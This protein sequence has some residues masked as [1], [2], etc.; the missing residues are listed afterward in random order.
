MLSRGC[1]AR[2]GSKQKMKMFLKFSLILILA[3]I[4]S[5]VVAS[6]QD[7]PVDERPEPVLTDA[8]P[9]RQHPI[10]IGE[11]KDRPLPSA[12]TSVDV[13]ERVQ[14]AELKTL[15]ERFETAREKYLLDQRELFRQLKE[16]TDT[17]REELRNKMR[18]DLEAWREMQ[19]E[20]RAQVKERAREIRE[21]LSRDL[22]R[23]VESGSKSGDGQRPRD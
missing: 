8:K 18:D 15:I 1:S 6:A 4:V 10:K 12:V 20:L 3:L 17:Q 2:F 7:K 11:R 22:E 9:I 23:V 13:P 21:E 16:S 14:P 19:L 5:S